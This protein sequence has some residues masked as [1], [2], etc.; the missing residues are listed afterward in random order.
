MG[1]L[2]G[3]KKLG[4]KLGRKVGKVAGSKAGQLVLGAVST[5]YTGSP[6][7]GLAISG[8]AGAIGNRKSLRAKAMKQQ[9][10]SLPDVVSTQS[11][12]ELSAALSDGLDF[13]DIATFGK[14]LA[15]PSSGA[16]RPT[17]ISPI[18]DVPEQVANGSEGVP[19]AA[20]PKSMHMDKTL[21]LV[22]AALAVVLVVVFVA[23]SRRG[24]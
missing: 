21:V 12:G 19:P 4:K 14:L 18:N 8:A 3:L 7:A 15:P 11:I 6:T 2:H 1:G 20:E 9:A 10:A 17:G 24:A 5:V 13:G 22:G 23:T 16:P